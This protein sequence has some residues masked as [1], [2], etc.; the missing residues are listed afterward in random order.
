MQPVYGPERPPP[1]VSSPKALGMFARSIQVS[2]PSFSSG[3]PSGK[4]KEERMVAE[5]SKYYSGIYPCAPGDNPLS[6]W[7]VCL[8]RSL[9]TL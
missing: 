5:L 4:S 3:N 7:K 1:P 9:R 8:V 6:W 2:T